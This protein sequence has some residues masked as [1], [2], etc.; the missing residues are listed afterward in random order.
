[1]LKEQR[2]HTD[3]VGFE[4]AGSR[5]QRRKQHMLLQGN[6]EVQAGGGLPSPFSVFIRNTDPNY[7]EG[8]IKKYLLDCAAAMPE[9]DKLKDEL[10]IVQVC[11]I[12]L[13]RRDGAPPRSKCWKVTRT[14]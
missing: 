12:P 5:K 4:P 9:E 13:N 8:D 6:S 3:Q 10:Q 7:T 2:Q 11:H 1:M 14:I